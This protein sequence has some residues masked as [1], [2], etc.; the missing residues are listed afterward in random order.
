MTK[1]RSLFSFGQMRSRYSG[2]IDTLSAMTYMGFSQSRKNQRRLEAL[3]KIL[4][5]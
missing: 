3:Q 4:D 1:G 5:F 2:I